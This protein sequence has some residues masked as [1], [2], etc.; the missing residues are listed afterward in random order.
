MFPSS[1]QRT[2]V[3]VAVVVTTALVGCSGSTPS[4]PSESQA[5]A[6]TGPVTAATPPKKT[7]E[8][9]VGEAVDF[10]AILKK[11]V[12]GDYFNYGGL[13]ANPEDMNRFAAFLRWQG[14]VDLALLSRE[15]Q[16]AFYINAYNACCIKAI[17]DHYPVKTPKDIP[18]F[19]DQ[20]KFPVAGESLTINEIEYDRLI[21]KYRDM[22]A[23]FA[24][25]CSDRSCLPLKPGAYTGSKLNLELEGAAKQFVK[26]DQH[27]RVD[28][29]KKVV[30]V[31][32]IFDW[33]GKKFLKDEQRP[34]KG[35]RPELFLLP[36]LDGETRKLLE[37]GEYRLE[38]IEWDWTLNERT[39][40]KEQS[41]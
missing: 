39:S 36:W 18:G 33:Y 32:K 7:D 31:S 37:G 29:E 5:A 14:Q 19:F 20:L 28:H 10:D 25:V 1:Q 35:E 27:F 3:L 16:I 6:A 21:A 40:P 15:D 22:R 4:P 11:Y 34:V 24:V 38:F 9:P 30:Y 41:N 17:L 13:K 12:D 8:L 26:S 2:A 23:H